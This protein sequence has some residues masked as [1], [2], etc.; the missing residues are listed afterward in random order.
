MTDIIYFLYW[1]LEQ[2]PFWT[3][4]L[5]PHVMF[6]YCVYKGYIFNG[7]CAFIMIGVHASKD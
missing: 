7:I 1:M 4:I 3:T 6:M 5:A 2:H